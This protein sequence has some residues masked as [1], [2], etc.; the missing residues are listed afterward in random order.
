MGGRELDG[1]TVEQGFMSATSP[2]RLQVVR[3]SP[4]VVVDAAHN[5]AGARS[6]RDALEETFDFT[7]VVAVFAAMADKDVEGMLAELEPS[8]EHVV[9]TALAGERAMPVEDLRAIAVDVFG[10]DRVD[11]RE[12]LPEAIDR[13]VELTEASLDPADTTGIVVFGSIVLAGEVTALLRPQR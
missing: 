11:V 7:H 3:T 10:P 2:G 4:T 5:P 13:A 1:R 9:I 6:L 12:D 8:I